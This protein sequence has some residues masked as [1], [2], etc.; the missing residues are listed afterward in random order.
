ME[1]YEA[2]AHDCYMPLIRGYGF[3]FAILDGDEFFL[4]GNGFALYIFVDRQ[5]RRADVWYVLPNSKGEILAYTLM[6]IQKNRYTQEDFSLYGNPNSVD[7]KIKSDMRVDVSGLMNRCQD[8]LTGDTSWLKNYPGEG[9]FSRHITRFLAPYF[10]RQ[11][12]YL[13][14]IEE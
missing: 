11:G 13:K 3:E 2:M 5:D 14:L 1:S 10:R 9:S 7:E 4:I 12:Y 8:I 6:Y